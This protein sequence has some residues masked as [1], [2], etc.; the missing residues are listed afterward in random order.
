MVIHLSMAQAPSSPHAI[1][2]FRN[3]PKYKFPWPEHENII[4]NNTSQKD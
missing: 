3:E 1:S 2:V 4:K